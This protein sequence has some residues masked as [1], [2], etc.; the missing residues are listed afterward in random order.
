MTRCL[1][2]IRGRSQSATGRR[3][4]QTRSTHCAVL[5]YSAALRFLARRSTGSTKP[6]GMRSG[7]SA[8]TS[9][10]CWPSTPAALRWRARRRPATIGP[11][12][13][14]LWRCALR[15]GPCPRRTTRP[16]F[17]AGPKMPGRG[18][19]PRTMPS[20]D[21]LL[22][23]S[24]EIKPRPRKVS[25]RPRDGRFPRVAMPGRPKRTAKMRRRF[26]LRT[27]TSLPCTDARPAR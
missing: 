12:S 15:S 13:A 7:S 6:R 22:V 16:V 1:R 10:V 14:W 17:H 4:S 2:P 25:A 18:I 9:R 26:A 5:R 11:L 21:K 8:P 23:I 27:T 20:Y 24:R 3:A 19:S